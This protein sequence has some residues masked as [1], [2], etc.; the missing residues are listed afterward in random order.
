MIGGFF[1]SSRFLTAAFLFFIPFLL[2]AENYVLNNENDIIGQRVV[3]KINEMGKE[4]FEKDGI[5]VYVS[6]SESIGDTSI[7]DY[8]DI[9]AKEI[10]TPYVLLIMVS[11]DKIIDIIS[12]DEAI[13]K[14]FNKEQI[15]SPI[16]YYGTIKPILT[17]KKD[18][19]SFSA[20]TLN[21]YADIV[22]QIA[23]SD[24]LKLESALGNGNKDTLY[25]V[26]A[27]VYTMFA[28]ALFVYIYTRIKYYYVKKKK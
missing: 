27:I 13:G 17:I 10:K 5:S 4:L 11:E 9:L 28:V 23:E 20:A 7:K 18:L 24:N 26:R 19:D 2:Q 3:K 8:I 6:L 16:P 1:K 14:K 22:E 15:L 25:Y 12:S 21:G